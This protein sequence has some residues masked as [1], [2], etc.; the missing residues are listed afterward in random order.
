[1]IYES[2]VIR[3]A[4]KRMAESVEEEIDADIL[5]WRAYLDGAKAMKKEYERRM[6]NDW[7]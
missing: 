1:M 2:E 7:T 3:F 6:E 5:Y 4:E